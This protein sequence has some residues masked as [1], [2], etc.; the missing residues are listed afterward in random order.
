LF[1]SEVEC[2]SENSDFYLSALL[3]VSNRFTSS[4]ASSGTGR[5]AERILIAAARRR[6][7][8]MRYKYKKRA[9]VVARVQWQGVND[10]VGL[11]NTHVKSG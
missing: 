5:K 6:P 9:A 2:H 8:A 3:Y 11:E 7:M 4:G 1:R 10:K